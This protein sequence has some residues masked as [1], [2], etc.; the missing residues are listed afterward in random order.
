MRRDCPTPFKQRFS[1]R[2]E[3]REASLEI[4]DRMRRQTG[5]KRVAKNRPAVYECRCGGWH[6]TSKRPNGV[7][8]LSV[9]D[10]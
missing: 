4:R 1:I 9:W 10:E 7:V 5:R 2:R 6:L 3:A 8:R